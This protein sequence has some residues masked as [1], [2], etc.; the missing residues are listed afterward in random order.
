MSFQNLSGARQKLLAAGFDMEQRAD[1]SALTTLFQKR[2]AISHQ[3]GVA[4]QEYLGRTRRQGVP[5]SANA[6]IECRGNRQW[7]ETMPAFDQR[8]LRSVFVLK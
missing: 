6:A 3:L 4:D 7:S 1:W 2:H 8:F 5:R